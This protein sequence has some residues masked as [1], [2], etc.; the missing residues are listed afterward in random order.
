MGYKEALSILTQQLTRYYKSMCR[1]PMCRAFA[2]KDETREHLSREWPALQST[3]LTV[4]GEEEPSVEV[5]ASHFVQNVKWIAA[6]I[7]F[8]QPIN[9][10]IKGKTTE[11]MM[12]GDNDKFE[13]KK[14]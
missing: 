2:K 11:K 8:C 4:S 13:T 3:R 5:I 14:I 12:T 7:A 9:Q 10:Q 6:S 1:G